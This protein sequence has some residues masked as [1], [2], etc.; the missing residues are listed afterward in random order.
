MYLTCIFPVTNL[1]KSRKQIALIK[2]N[3]ISMLF[4]SLSKWVSSPCTRHFLYRYHFVYFLLSLRQIKIYIK[5]FLFTCQRWNLAGIG[6]NWMNQIIFDYD[7]TN[8]VEHNCRISL[9]D[10]ISCG[11]LWFV[12]WN[13]A[14][15]WRCAYI[16]QSI[17]VIYS[18]VWIAINYRIE[19]WN[20]VQLLYCMFP[21]L[22][23][24]NP[25]ENVWAWAYQYFSSLRNMLH[26]YTIHCIVYS[27]Y[28]E[29]LKSMEKTES[30]NIEFSQNPFSKHIFN[31][32]LQFS[33]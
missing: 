14:G 25:I 27:L 4:N 17:I 24:S 21:N 23:Q 10:G 1:E 3:S 13:L 7:F 22:I 12:H 9:H 26:M 32:K 15:S 11:I 8:L 29:K 16:L 20:N 33:T 6:F 30:S 28:F 31:T 2:K 18:T 19:N 5:S